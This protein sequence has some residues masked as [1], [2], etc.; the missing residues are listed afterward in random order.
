MITLSRGS[1]W[2]SAR[3]ACR[4]FRFGGQRKTDPQA[5][6]QVG[7]TPGKPIL[8]YSLGGALPTNVPA[9]GRLRWF[10]GGPAKTYRAPWAAK[11]HKKTPTPRAR[12]GQASKTAS[13]A[14]ERAAGRQKKG[15]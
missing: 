14:G 12:G 5:W 8:V 10:A 13:K 9:S 2:H 6:P 7:E 3:H 11:A 1:T 15:G 4:R